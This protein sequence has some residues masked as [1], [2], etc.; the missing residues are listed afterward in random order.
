MLVVHY[1]AQGEDLNSRKSVT[2]KPK[3]QPQYFSKPTIRCPDFFRRVLEA[4]QIRGRIFGDLD[5]I[6]VPS[7]LRAIN[8]DLS[9]SDCERRKFCYPFRAVFTNIEIQ[10]LLA[11]L[12]RLQKHRIIVWGEV[13]HLLTTT[14]DP[15]THNRNVSIE[16][17]VA[18]ITMNEQWLH[19]ARNRF[20][21][22]QNKNISWDARRMMIENSRPSLS[23]PGAW[24][25]L[26]EVYI[27]GVAD[28]GYDYVQEYQ[29]DWI[30]AANC[31]RMLDNNLR[32]NLP[33]TLFASTCID[34][35]QYWSAG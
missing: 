32:L 31:C 14:E 6:D 1:E 19:H 25:A 20:T 21:K 17:C 35:F 30:G 29:S 15:S 28:V 12:R 22:H 26:P 10:R 4:Y 24:I 8:I 2:M 7:I 3:T 11:D 33:R 13:D 5:A 27:D 18:E 16:I 34:D 23:L 9:I